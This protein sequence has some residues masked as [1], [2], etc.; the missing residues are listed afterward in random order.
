MATG[1]IRRRLEF[2]RAAEEL[3]ALM[4]VELGRR[5]RLDK[6]Q[7]ALELGEL[8]SGLTKLRTEFEAAE[9]AELAGAIHEGLTGSEAR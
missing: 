9:R 6:R 5:R 4:R 1:W 2:L 3:T 7:L 8:R